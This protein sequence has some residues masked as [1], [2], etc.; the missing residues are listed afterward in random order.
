MVTHLIPPPANDADKEAFVD[1]IREGGY[2][3]E[4]IVCD[5]LSTVTLG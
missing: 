1:D 2:T 4:L 3:G 5:D